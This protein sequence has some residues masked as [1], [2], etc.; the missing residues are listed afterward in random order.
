MSLSWL[1]DNSLAKETNGINGVNSRRLNDCLLLL[2][3]EMEDPVPPV[4]KMAK[5]TSFFVP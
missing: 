1:F 3:K 5:G 4:S 2:G